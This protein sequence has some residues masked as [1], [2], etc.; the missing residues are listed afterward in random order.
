MSDYLWNPLHEPDPDVKAFEER[1]A[2]L[3]REPRRIN[4]RAQ[5]S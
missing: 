4:H 3:R 1:L 5:V 2:P